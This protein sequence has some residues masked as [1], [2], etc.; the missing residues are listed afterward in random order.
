MYDSARTS[1][2]ISERIDVRSVARSTRTTYG[3]DAYTHRSPGILS[4]RTQ[5]KR[6]VNQYRVTNPVAYREKLQ[7]K[8]MT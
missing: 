5:N 1:E 4:Y 6:T 3:R 7:E 8:V 2:G